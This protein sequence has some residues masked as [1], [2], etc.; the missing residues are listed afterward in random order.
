MIVINY[1]ANDA[2][3]P[4]EEYIKAYSGFLSLVREINPSAK[5]VVLSAFMGVYPKELGEMVEKYNS[6]Q[7]DDVLFIDSAGWIPKEP[8]HPLRDGHRVIA[9]HLSK[10]LKEKLDI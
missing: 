6:E 5:I 4:A 10:I 2:S 1:G 8:V 9:E 3:A 7:N